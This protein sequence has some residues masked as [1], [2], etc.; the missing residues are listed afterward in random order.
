MWAVGLMLAGTPVLAGSSEREAAAEAYRLSEEATRL[1]QKGAW[2]GVERTYLRAVE[3]GAPLS[4][5][6]HLTGARS[7]MQIGDATEARQRLL[8]AYELERDPEVLAWLTTYSRQYTRVTLK[9]DP[10]AKL[11][12]ERRHFDAERARVVDRAAEI[13]AE[14]G[15]FDGLLPMGRYRVGAFWFKV[16]ED[17]ADIEQDLR[18]CAK[19]GT[20]EAAP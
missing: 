6:M 1:V 17:D 13:L 14:T 5:A 15:A 2:Q 10:G 19:S 3:T 16:R 4:A 11:E 12:V 7:S 20:C 18:A 9:V 8:S